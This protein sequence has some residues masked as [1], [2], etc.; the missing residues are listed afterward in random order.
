MGVMFCVD[1]WI[2]VTIGQ[3]TT[4]AISA[5]H[6]PIQGSGPRRRQIG[7]AATGR[8]DGGAGAIGRPAVSSTAVLSDMLTPGLAS[9][10]ARR[11]LL[12]RVEDLLRVTGNGLAERGLD[13]VLHR[14]PVRVGRV[15]HRRRD[16]LEERRE[17]GVAGHRAGRAQ[18]GWEQPVL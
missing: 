5:R 1:V 11:R 3:S 7:A 14:G 8:R 4:T 6:G 2:M 16:V 17:H 12:D 13:L 18:G 9:A 15:V 10:A